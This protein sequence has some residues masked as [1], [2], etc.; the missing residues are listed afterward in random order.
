[1]MNNGNENEKKM[2]VPI[3]IPTAFPKYNCV[4][5]INDRRVM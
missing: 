3:C 4:N 1:M 5:S 2:C